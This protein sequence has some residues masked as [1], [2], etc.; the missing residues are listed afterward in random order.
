[1]ID[2]TK[3]EQDVLDGLIAGYTKKELGYRFQLD[4]RTISTHV[5]SIRKKMNVQNDTQLG[6]QLEKANHQCPCET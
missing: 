1:M 4:V 5:V 6:I 2:L 3:R